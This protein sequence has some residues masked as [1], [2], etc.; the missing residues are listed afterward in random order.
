[1][2]SVKVFSQD[3]QEVGEIGLQENVFSVSVKPEVLHLAVRAHRAAE[4]SGTASVKNRAS[5]SGGG[6]KPWRQKGTGRARTGS[7]RSPLWR[8]GAVIHGP[9]PRDFSI[10]LNKKVRRL[11]LKMALS[12]KFAQKRL[13][14]VD[15]LELPEIRTKDFVNFKSKLGLKK[16]LIVTAEQCNNLKLS[17]RNV[18]GVE[19]VTQTSINVYEILKH[20]EL[21][22]DKPAVEKLQ[23]RLS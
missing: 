6:R 3:N 17:A 15:N 9:K 14:V 21:I 1:M 5:I 19:V 18:P 16:P 11:A 7:G 22:M 23:E 13:L 20:R 8:G 4:R 12:A 10:K 2:I